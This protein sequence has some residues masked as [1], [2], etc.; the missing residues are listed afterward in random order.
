MSLSSKKEAVEEPCVRDERHQGKSN[1]VPGTRTLLRGSQGRGYPGR[2]LECYAATAAS[3]RRQSV[4]PVNLT[5]QMF[6]RCPSG[7]AE[8]QPE[9]GSCPPRSR[10]T[11]ELLYPASA[12]LRRLPAL[13]T[14]PSGPSA[15]V[16]VSRSPG[17]AGRCPRHRCHPL[18]AGNPR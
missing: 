16:L 1:R 10:I 2:P 15:V 3:P 6:P 18:P 14:T 12:A 11:T 13:L 4:D 8:A 7:P 17:R 9:P 5:T